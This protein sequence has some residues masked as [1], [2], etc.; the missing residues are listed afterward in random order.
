ME[1]LKNLIQ[2]THLCTL[3]DSLE[4][5]FWS[6]AYQVHC[7]SENPEAQLK[8]YCLTIANFSAELFYYFDF[9]IRN[10]SGVESVFYIKNL[11]VFVL[12]RIKIL[13]PRMCIWV[14]KYLFIRFYW[15]WY[16]FYS[17]SLNLFPW[18]CHLDRWYWRIC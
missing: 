3:N 10:S 1:C 12:L 15:C 6:V 17:T 9:H 14:I 13:L 2:L 4:E 8:M 16:Y 5:N 7:L 11:I 18:S